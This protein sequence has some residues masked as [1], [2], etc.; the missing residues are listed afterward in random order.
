M[1]GY[2]YARAVTI[3]EAALRIKYTE[4]TGRKKV[5]KEKPSLNT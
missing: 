5:R 1:L 2:S 3:I 4:L